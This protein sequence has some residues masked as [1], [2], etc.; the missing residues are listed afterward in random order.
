MAKVH[1]NDFLFL[2]KQNIT[3][4]YSRSPDS[5]RHAGVCKGNVI[6]RGKM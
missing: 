3:S 4:Q 6:I 5:L 1:Y 2:D